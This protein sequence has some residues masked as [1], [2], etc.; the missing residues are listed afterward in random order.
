MEF[1]SP[2]EVLEYQHD[3][4]LE[5]GADTITTSTWALDSGIYKDSNSKTDTVST[6][7]ISGGTAGQTYSVANTIVTAAGR[8]HHKAFYLRVQ[9]QRAG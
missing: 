6:I 9:E 1:K 4:S 2:S 3:I 8:T 5:L 7:W